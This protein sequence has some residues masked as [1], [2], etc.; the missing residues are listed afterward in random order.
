[1]KEYGGSGVIA[2]WQAQSYLSV[3][4]I[5]SDY[6]S[7]NTTHEYYIHYILLQL[8]YLLFAKGRPPPRKHTFF[9]F[10]CMTTRYGRRRW[11][12]HVVAQYNEYNILVLCYSG[13]TVHI[14]QLNLIS[15]LHGS[16]QSTLHLPQLYSCKRIRYSLSREL[17]L[18]Q[19]WYGYCGRE[20]IP[21]PLPGFETRIVQSVAQFLH[22]L[23][24]LLVFRITCY[25]QGNQESVFDLV[26]CFTIGQSW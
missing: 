26:T 19:S 23:R 20:E 18:P 15:T 7:E 10:A 4:M 2:S 11:P 5:S 8:P 12:K 6:K 16:Q 9:L 17:S 1:M 13:P 25:L 14:V 24:S 3:D 21:L 22:R